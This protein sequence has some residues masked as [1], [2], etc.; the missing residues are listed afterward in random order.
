MTM[1]KHRR[2]MPAFQITEPVE[3]T[4]HAEPYSA[5]EPSRTSCTADSV[6]HWK[7]PQCSPRYYARQ[8][9]KHRLRGPVNG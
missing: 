3:A 4:R 6:G 7:C 8:C 9:A 1:T 5:L 2:D